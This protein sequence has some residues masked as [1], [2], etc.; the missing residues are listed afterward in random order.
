MLHLQVSTMSLDP[1]NVPELPP[2]LDDETFS[3]L[4]SLSSQFL[5]EYD[6]SISPTG[7]IESPQATSSTSFLHQ[8]PVRSW[9]Y[10]HGTLTTYKGKRVWECQLCSSNPQRYAYGTT[11]HPMKHLLKVHKITEQGSLPT[12]E[13]P[14]GN[15]IPNI[16]QLFLVTG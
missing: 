3:Q 12:S 14:G 11:G 8:C 5:S 16:L 7:D 6:D 13:S 1:Q 15:N 2:L 10:Q 9:I 4:T